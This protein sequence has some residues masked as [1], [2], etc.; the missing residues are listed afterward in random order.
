MDST[1]Q[2]E[3]KVRQR[4]RIRFCKQGD[5]RLVGHRDLARLL[6]RLCRR[7][8]LGLAMSEGFHPKPRMSF[9]SA[10]AV[11]IEGL[12]EVMEVELARTY[13]ADDVLFRLRAHAT[14]GLEFRSVDFLPPGPK[15]QK[16]RLGSVT[17]RIAIPAARREEAAGRI[18]RLLASPA[19]RVVRRGRDE[20]I[21]LGDSL[22]SLALDEGMLSMRFRVTQRAGPG[23]R[24]LLAA[25][26]LDD[27]EPC[28]ACLRRTAVEV[29]P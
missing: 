18:E 29:L 20:P 8:G 10:L 25:L 16:A 7:A 11:G 22:E 13:S 3:P 19:R 23:P 28:G 12:D 14:P 4:V 5:L 26:G 27:L 24:D 2:G 15:K 1:P 6:Q 21:D 9:P 17:Y